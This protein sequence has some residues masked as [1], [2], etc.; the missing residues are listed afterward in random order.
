MNKPGLPWARLYNLESQIG[1]KRNVSTIRRKEGKPPS[2]IPRIKKTISLSHEELRVLDS[3]TGSIKE[4]FAPANI[5]GSQVAGFAIQFL[6]TSI[7]AAG[8]LG[9]VS[10]WSHLIERLMEGHEKRV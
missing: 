6:A 1:Q 7:D 4:Q 2:P 3:L 8:G 9:E 5:F 10:D